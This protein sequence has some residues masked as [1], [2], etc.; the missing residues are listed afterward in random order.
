LHKHLKTIVVNKK[1][2]TR[3]PFLRGILTRSLLDAGLEFENAFD[4]ATRVRDQFSDEAEVSSDEIRLS[5]SKLLENNGYL[6]ALE[7][8]RLPI[9]APAKIQVCS[10][11][12]T[13]SA[14]SRGKHERYLQ[15]SGMKAERA[16]QTTVMIYD[17]LL[18]AG[19]SAVTTCQLGYL[20]FLCLRQEVSKKAAKRY[21][22]W[23]EFQRAARPLLLLICGTVGTGKSTIAT[24]I[25][26][27]LDIVRI[28]STD[29]LREVMRMMMPQRLL[30]VLHKSSFNAWKALPIQDVKDRDR[31]QIVADGYRSQADLLAVPCEAVLQRAVEESVPI[32]LEGVHAHPGLME[33]LP[34][35]SD[36]IGVHVTLAVLNT[37]ELKSRLRGRGVEVPQRRAKRYLN[38]FDA[39]WSLQ[40]YLLSEADRCDVPIITNQDKEK[41]ALQVIL[42]VN[43]E[44][45]RHF[46][47]SPR[48]IFGTVVDSVQDRAE[49][50][51]WQDLVPLLSEPGETGSSSPS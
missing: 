49:T 23:S 18:A 1:E 17:Q 4:L 22:V 21:L 14:F 12:G 11:S 8:Y 35:D 19:V 39:V 10:L 41:A 20:T 15:A 32:I 37:K 45:S 33:L 36:A 31:D 13:V 38:K 29:M 40:S 43:Y 42:Q 25:A 28:Q 30:P 48:D 51:A 16:E 34:A 26:H 50:E 44:L 2:K 24:E 6:G 46:R 7:P 3:V 5:V 47:G 27:L 9:A